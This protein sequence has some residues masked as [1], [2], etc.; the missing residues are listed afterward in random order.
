MSSSEDPRLRLLEAAGQVFAE[1]GFDG[2]TVRDICR[3]AGANIAAVNYYFRDKER[4]Y[5]EAVKGASCGSLEDSPL[6]TWPSGTAPEI[7]LRDFIRERAVQM[8]RPDKPDWHT[9]LMMREMAHPTSACSEWVRDY[10]R[11]HSEQLGDILGELMPPGTPAF[12]RFLTG[13]SIM[14]QCLF[15]IH[16][17]P[18]AQALMG[19]EY[20]RIT[21]E[22][23]AD[24]VTAFSLAALG[25][26]TPRPKA[27]RAARG[28][29]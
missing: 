27:A 18:V 19:D 29:S 3:R 24:H 22:A 12:S 2:A 1:K 9:Q 13:F 4:L 17:K 26:K 23:V 25:V 16:C 20:R 7:K 6:L 15:Y 14:G 8:L 28:Q 5:I 10:V 11:P 21:A